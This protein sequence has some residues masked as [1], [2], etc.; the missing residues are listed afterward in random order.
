MPLKLKAAY[1]FK[2][3][4]KLYPL[5]RISPTSYSL[6]ITGIKLLTNHFNLKLRPMLVLL[7]NDAETSILKV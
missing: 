6:Q 3:T 2:G 5:K 7:A 1:Q 4:L